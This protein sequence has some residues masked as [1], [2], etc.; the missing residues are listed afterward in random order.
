M[1]AT[2]L[3]LVVYLGGVVAFTALTPPALPDFEMF[4]GDRGMIWK[5]VILV[6][7]VKSILGAVA[8]EREQRGSP[9]PLPAR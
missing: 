5:I 1:P 9:E 4:H 3:A 6:G 2:V 7:L 8:Y